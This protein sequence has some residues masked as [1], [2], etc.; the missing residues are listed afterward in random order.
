MTIRRSL[1][2]AADASLQQWRRQLIDRRRFL[3]SMAGGSLAALMPLRTL[4]GATAREM[5]EDM[6]WKL[7]DAV[8]Q[9]LLPSEAQAPGARE[10]KAL[11]YLKFVIGDKG[12]DAEDRAFLLRGPEWLEDLTQNMLRKSFLELSHQEKEQVLQRI[13]ASPTGENWLSS[14]QLYLCEAM[15]A[16]PVY[17]GN[18]NGIGW[19]WLGH[20]PGFPRPNES[21][22]YRGS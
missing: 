14:L 1:P 22:R 8:Q 9:H 13:A 17:G 12:L 18:P 19:K 16:D 10:L 3:L 2:S 5:D 4:Q 11:D 7:L 15:I 20:N 21:N 6:R